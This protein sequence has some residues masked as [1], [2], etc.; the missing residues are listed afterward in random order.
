[1]I[2]KEYYCSFFGGEE[3]RAGVR[4]QLAVSEK[5]STVGGPPI[6]RQIVAQSSAACPQLERLFI[7]RKERNESAE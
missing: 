1:M 6:V 4:S 3:R 7:S 5:N 2:S